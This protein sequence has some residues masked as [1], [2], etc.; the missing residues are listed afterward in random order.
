MTTTNDPLERKALADMALERAAARLKELL[1]DAAQELRPFPPYP[2]AFFTNAI[3]VDAPGFH[4]P[5]L[6]CVVVREDGELC[7]LKLSI[8][9]DE[10][11]PDP[12][13]ARDEKLAPLADLHPRDY[14]VYAYTALLQITELL[15]ERSG[16]RP[17]ARPAAGSA[18]DPAA[19]T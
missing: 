8:N 13:H 18:P 9:F 17:E 19:P 3:E 14:I 4:S 10:S 12:V 16:D 6:G 1:R 11:N 7:E 2:G 15:L 5:D